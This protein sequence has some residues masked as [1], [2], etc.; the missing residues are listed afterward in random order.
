MEKEWEAG[1]REGR[2]TVWVTI[3][4][5]YEGDGEDSVVLAPRQVKKIIR[6]QKLLRRWTYHRAWGPTGSEGWR[7]GE[8]QNDSQLSDEGNVDEGAIC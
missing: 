6:T 5:T 7:E 2:G 4:T 3:S 8:A 1:K